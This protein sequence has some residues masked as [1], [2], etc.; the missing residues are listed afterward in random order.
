MHL[1]SVELRR[2]KQF[3]KSDVAL[4][5]GLSIVAGG[6][7]AGKSSLLQALA[8]WE[9][10]KVAT[11]AQ[12]GSRALLNGMTSSQGFGLGDDEFSP[13]NVPSL[14]HLWSNLK[15]Q[16][17]DEDP[18]GYTL[19]IACEWKDGETEHKLAFSLALA[20]D[21]LFIKVAETTMH[22]GDRPPV[23]AYLPPFAGIS[24]REERTYGA[25]RR[26][27]IGE[28]LAG[29]ILRNLLLDMRDANTAERKRLRG[30]KQKISDPDLR[31]LRASDP[32]ELLQQTLREVFSA[33]ISIA[34]FDDEYHTYIQANVVKGKVDGHLLTRHAGY[35]SRDLMVEGSGFLQWLSVYT[36]ATSS[37]VDILLFDE[38]DAHLHASLQ[39]QL[40]DRLRYLARRFDKQVL[41][42]THSSE[43][44]KTTDPTDI[45]E[46]RTGGKFR[47]LKSEE[48]Q[49]GLL[50]GIGS[51]YAPRIEKVRDSKKIFFYEGTSDASVLRAIGETIGSPLPTSVALWRTSDQHKERKVLW[52]ALDDEF[53][54]IEAFSLRD[55]DEDP[56]TTV[57]GDLE[58]KRVPAVQGFVTRKWRRRYIESYLV[59]P[60]PLARASGMS[61]EQ[62]REV[63]QNDF[64]LAIGANFTDADVPATLCDIHAKDILSRFGVSAVKVAKEFLIDE[65]CDDVKTVLTQ[66]EEFGTN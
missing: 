31:A 4:M 44:L 20:N 65:V 63:L 9:F 35:N 59:H 17:T 19:L 56:I 39:A 46:V 43:I 53:G 36:L 1:T 21:R 18:D 49:V 5:P 62:V 37:S 51:T 32:W 11:V 22:D 57:G 23:L 38:P 15:T 64:A 47:Y 29:A 60:G 45:L 58:D 48:Q 2:F 40:V 50:V 25:L 55:R 24:A 33:E 27:R 61:E 54:S 10:C 30:E 42:A 8:V 7:N 26:R 6:N 12:K 34:D 41:L 66:L 28:G 3:G 13:I 14:K 16:K 52:R